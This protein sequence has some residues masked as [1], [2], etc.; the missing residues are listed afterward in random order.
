MMEQAATAR[1]AGFAGAASTA[2]LALLPKLTCPLC[3]PAYSAALGALGISFVD[4]TPYLLPVTA[5]FVVAAIAALAWRAR[6]RR[7]ILPLAA[8]AV[9]GALL[10]LGKFALDSEL[11]TY[12]G[13]G[14]FLV[15]AFLPVRFSA[16][17]TCGDCGC[18]QVKEVR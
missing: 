2:L 16:P 10:L 8:G 14:L 9:A 11:V 15:A 4:Y 5:I 17:A 7:S 13:A 18:E 3:W 12:G 1:S 6:L